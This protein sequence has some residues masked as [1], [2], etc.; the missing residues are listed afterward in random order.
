MWAVV[1]SVQ[2][3]YADHMLQMLTLH[4]EL[5][6]GASSDVISLTF[7]FIRLKG[8]IVYQNKPKE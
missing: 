5:D 1:K 2:K 8:E 3:E 7:I 4:P 6:Y